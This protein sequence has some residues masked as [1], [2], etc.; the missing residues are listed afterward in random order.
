MSIIYRTQ[1]TVNNTFR[2]LKAKTNQPRSQ[3]SLLS[4]L[5]SEPWERGWK[6]TLIL[7]TT[8]YVMAVWRTGL[9][10]TKRRYMEKNI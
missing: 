3:G 2:N 5:Q 7:I 4:A 1:Y 10:L 8:S 6:R 9:F